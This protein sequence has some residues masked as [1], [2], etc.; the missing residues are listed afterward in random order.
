MIS[1]IS[2]LYLCYICYLI[3]S[4]F[5]YN[6]ITVVTFTYIYIYIYNNYFFVGVI[7]IFKTYVQYIIFY[8]YIY[9]PTDNKG[10]SNF[11]PSNG[12][13]AHARIAYSNGSFVSIHSI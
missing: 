1:K 12:K 13:E 5:N 8:I 11:N 10:F 9:L 7:F 4:N 3:N 2:A 6:K